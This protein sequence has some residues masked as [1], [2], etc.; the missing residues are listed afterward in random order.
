MNR[1]L[2]AD[3]EKNLASILKYELEDEGH[4]VDVADRGTFNE[5]VFPGNATCAAVLL[6]MQ[7]FCLDYCNRLKRIKRNN[8][9]GRIIIFTNHAAAEE[10]ASLINAGAEECFAK[11]EIDRL[12]I[13]LRQLK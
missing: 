12:K 8:P 11:H 6:N 9:A 2:I 10:R 3:V 7:M 1:I 4:S 13:Y 5:A